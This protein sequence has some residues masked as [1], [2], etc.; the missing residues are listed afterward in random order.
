[1]H[2]NI[3][4]S[5]YFPNGIKLEDEIEVAQTLGIR[6]HSTRGS[7]SIGESN[8]GLPPDYLVED[9]SFII[10]DSQDIINKWHDPSHGSMIRIALAPCSPFSVSKELMRDTAILAR[11]YNVG[12]I[13]I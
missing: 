5:L 12:C 10:K 11:E 6:F 8:G 7:M 9:E 1:M 2:D 4:S 13:L 3:R